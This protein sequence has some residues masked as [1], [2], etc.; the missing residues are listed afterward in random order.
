[1]SEYATACCNNE[2]V[3]WVTEESSITSRLTSSA[4][5]QGKTCKLYDKLFNVQKQPG[6]IINI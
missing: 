4:Q 6:N 1:M 5:A 2:T 3:R